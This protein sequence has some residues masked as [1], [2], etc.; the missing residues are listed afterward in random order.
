MEMQVKIRGEDASWE[1][2]RETLDKRRGFSGSQITITD[3]EELGPVGVSVERALGE[4]MYLHTLGWSRVPRKLFSRWSRWYQEIDDV[5]F[6]RLFPEEENLASAR[7]LAA[8][9]EAFI[10]GYPNDGR[11]YREWQSTVVLLKPI[12][13]SIFQAKSDCKALWA[14]QLNSTPEGHIKLNHRRG[15]D[16]IVAKPDIGEP[17][18][19]RVLDNGLEYRVFVNHKEVGSGRYFRDP[20]HRTKFR[21]G[22][23]VGS[24]RVRQEG[25][26]AFSGTTV[27]MHRRDRP[28][29]MHRILN[30]IRARRSRDD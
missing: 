11:Y 27:R 16:C 23:Y 14:I 30:A 3:R 15:D 12:G 4:E 29:G 18:H 20:K 21:W 22:F 1:V 28:R 9:T 5:Q 10:L 7:R 25:L 26:I 17:V 2:V 24:T 6:F 13:A 19:L 8:R